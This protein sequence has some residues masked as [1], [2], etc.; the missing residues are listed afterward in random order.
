MS[1]DKH[2]MKPIPDLEWS[3]PKNASYWTQKAGTVLWFI[4]WGIVCFN[5]GRGALGDCL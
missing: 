2:T 1:I 3:G 5:I 4:V